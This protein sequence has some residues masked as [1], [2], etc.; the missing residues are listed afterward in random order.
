M[1]FTQDTLRKLIAEEVESH[2]SEQSDIDDPL[3]AIATR[4][5]VMAK[6][7]KL[8][9]YINDLEDQLIKRGIDPDSPTV[10]P[11]G[12]QIVEPLA[13]TPV[14]EKPRRSSVATTRLLDPKN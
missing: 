11:S 14:G 12:T 9:A 5:E 10:G 2:L 1:K 3:R 13:D 6:L 4:E 8:Y 7:D